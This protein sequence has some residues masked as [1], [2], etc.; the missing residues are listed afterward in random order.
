MN[1]RHWLTETHCKRH[2]PLTPSCY[3]RAIVQNQALAPWQHRKHSGC[4]NIILSTRVCRCQAPGKLQ[5]PNCLKL[6]I[7]KDQSIFC[8]QDCFKVSLTL[9]LCM[10]SEAPW[11]PRQQE[12]QR[13]IGPDSAVVE[14]PFCQQAIFHMAE[15]IWTTLVFKPDMSKNIIEENCDICG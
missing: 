6:E 14:G 7:P 1:K 5:C 8:S 11:V 12:R 3:P 2:K 15:A 4:S 13:R 9:Y 10:S